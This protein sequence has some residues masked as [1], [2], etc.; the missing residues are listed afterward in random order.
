M[1]STTTQPLAIITGS[2]SGVGLHTAKALLARNW[3]LILA[4]RDPQKME[5]LA[6][7]HQFDSNQYEI[8]QLDLGSLDSVHA[9]VKRFNDSGQKLN[10]LLC[11]AA[12]YLPL[13]KEPARSPQGFEI[14]VATNYFGHYVLSRMLLENLKQTA[15][16]GEHARLI[17]LGTVTANSEEFG[18]KVPIPAPADIGALE[19]LVAGFKAPIAMINGKPFKPGKAYKDSKL[20][21]MIMNRELQKRYH[22]STGVIFNTL[23][24]GCVA[25]TA[26]F[27]DTP[28]LFQKIFPWFQKNITKGF[29]SQELAGERVAQVVADPRFTQSGVHWSWGN[30]NSAIRE[31]FAQEL[32]MKAK[33]EKLSRDL[34]EITAKLVGMPND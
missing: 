19:G 5:L 20:C 29:V 28:P 15:A 18:G 4:V 25:E 26:L 22:A 21:N 6:K 34:W 13:L 8:W 7:A 2:S 3:R 23:Y 12:T 9:F 31:P 32:S 27:R 30:R 1:N 14:S 10:A 11:N 24:P 16:K 17:T 33:S